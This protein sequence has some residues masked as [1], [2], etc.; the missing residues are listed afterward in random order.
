[1]ETNSLINGVLATNSKNPVVG[2]GATKLGWTDRHAYTVVHVCSPRKVIVRRDNATLVAGSCATE[3]QKYNFEPGQ[4]GFDKT[5]TLRKDGKWR[6]ANDGS[7]FTIG[8]RSE[9]RD[10]TF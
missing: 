9:Y 3:Y 10:P 4:E 1:M 5:V 7:L 8:E 6:V 2:M